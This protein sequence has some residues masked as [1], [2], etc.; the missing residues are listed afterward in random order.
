MSKWPPEKRAKFEKKAREYLEA[1]DAWIAARRRKWSAGTR[2]TIAAE[3]HISPKTVSN[4][5]TVL[6][7]R[8]S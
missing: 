5:F 6:K 4:L 2:S 3:F 8:S 1:R 7:R